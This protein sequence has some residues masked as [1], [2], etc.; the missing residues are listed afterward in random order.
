MYGGMYTGWCQAVDAI[1]HKGS[2]NID[3]WCGC[4]VTS[5]P[6]ECEQKERKK[7]GPRRRDCAGEVDFDFPAV[8]SSASGSVFRRADAGRVTAS[9][10]KK[11]I[12]TGIDRLLLESPGVGRRGFPCR[13]LLDRRRRWGWARGAQ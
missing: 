7:G 12:A 1:K 9:D 4:P 13:L 5:S 8:V 11:E 10:P 6:E 2:A 3:P